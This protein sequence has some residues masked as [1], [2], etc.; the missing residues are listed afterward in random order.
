[1]PGR[2]G[3]YELIER[4][5]RG[6]MGEVF[7]AR[8]FDSKDP[9]RAFVIK[10]V[11]PHLASDTA[12]RDRFLDEARIAARLSHPNIV[13]LVELG[14]VDGQWF[15]AM[16]HVAGKDLHAVQTAARSTG[17]LPLALSCR[18]VADAAAALAFSHQAHDPEG[19]PMHVV[20]GDVTPRNLLVG[21]DGVVKLIDFGVAHAASR[22]QRHGV[23]ALGGTTGYLSP[24]QALDEGVD[25]RSDQFSLGVVFWELLTGRHLFEA[26]DDAVTLARVVDCRVVAPREFNPSVPEGLEATVLRMLE[27]HPADRFPTCDAARAALEGWLRETR[28]EG[29]A[30]HLSRWMQA[31]FQTGSTGG[32][33]RTQGARHLDAEALFFERAQAARPGWTPTPSDRAAV[34]ALVTSFDG[35]PL[36]LELA[37]AQVA[38]VSPAELVRGPPFTGEVSLRAV[39]DWC[40]ALLEP[41]EQ[42]LLAQLGVFA[43]AFS[44]EALEAVVDV[45]ST[46]HAPWPLDVVQALKEQALVHVAEGP[47]GEVHFSLPEPV[48]SFARERLERLPPGVAEATRARHAAFMHGED[49]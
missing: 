10:R 40:W 33:A 18:V 36:A 39:L 37:A 11:L 9:E 41:H 38:R 23:G 2:F 29:T 15:I 46:P 4:L 42:D 47:R 34:Q 17:G 30:S 48:R 1:M 6:G 22:L 27:Q 19:R 44:L 28:A 5:A 32:R 7:L 24:E 8:R 14:E 26:D 35:L 12:F 16:E 43:G 20:H 21:F 49:R 45:S 3:R 13:H 25:A 31:T